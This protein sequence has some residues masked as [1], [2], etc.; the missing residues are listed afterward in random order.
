MKK[1]KVSII[2]VMIITIFFSLPTVV[3]ARGTEVVE[4]LYSENFEVGRKIKQRNEFVGKSL[5]RKKT[6]KIRVQDLEKILKNNL[7]SFTIEENALINE[8]NSKINYMLKSNQISE[9]EVI[10]E[11]IDYENGYVRIYENAMVSVTVIECLDKQTNTNNMLRAAYKNRTVQATR[12]DYN[13]AGMKMLSHKIKGTW[14]YNGKNVK[15]IT[16]SMS[17]YVSGIANLLRVSRLQYTLNNGTKGISQFGE[18]S[19]GGPFVGS[20]TW[21]F[22]LRI[23]VS[24][25]GGYGASWYSSY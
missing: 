8:K 16:S 14:Q 5:K 2:T 15:F 25:N 24:K 18:A 17:G 10:S 22:D 12:H 23:A 9:E 6:N 19:I 11:Q 3:N 21:H 7:N 13:G 20:S 1:I 4:K